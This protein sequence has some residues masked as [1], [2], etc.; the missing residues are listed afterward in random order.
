VFLQQKMEGGETR[1]ASILG[2]MGS[3]GETG[4]DGG[5]N[6]PLVELT[7]YACSQS[8]PASPADRYWL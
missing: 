2:P 5:G 6:E 1:S 4:K 8:I 3:Q 7:E